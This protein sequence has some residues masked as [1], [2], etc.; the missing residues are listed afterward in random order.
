MSWVLIIWYGSRFHKDR[1]VV[2]FFRAL[3]RRNTQ[4]IFENVYKKDIRIRNIPITFKFLV[5]NFFNER[6]K[7]AITMSKRVMVWIKSKY[8]ISEIYPSDCSR[9]VCSWW[10]YL[11]LNYRIEMIFSIF[12]NFVTTPI[13]RCKYSRESSVLL[14]N[15]SITFASPT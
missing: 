9:L 13:V 15:T 12:F 3:N 4:W 10:K 2:L 14:K 8:F 11:A 7:V 6:N 1:A 5:V